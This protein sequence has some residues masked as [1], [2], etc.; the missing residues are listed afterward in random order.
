MYS[1]TF[2]FSRGVVPMRQVQRYP[3]WINDITM[4]FKPGLSF[5]WHGQR[6]SR[7]VE[8]F[9]SGV[10]VSQIISNKHSFSCEILG[11]L[12][13]GACVICTLHDKVKKSNTYKEVH[14]KLS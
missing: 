9:T 11:Q 12:W 10:H 13:S 7:L 8:L 14:I 5:N 3:I 6:I 4:T 1:F 2:R